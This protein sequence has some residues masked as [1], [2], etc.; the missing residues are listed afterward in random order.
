MQAVW[1]RLIKVQSLLHNA[2][3]HIGLCGQEARRGLSV[4]SLT[5]VSKTV[6][7]TQGVLLSAGSNCAGGGMTLSQ[8]QCLYVFF[9][10]TGSLGGRQSFS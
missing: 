6:N 7:D 2:C 9:L 5:Y 3:D 8:L 1:V 4:I 10:V